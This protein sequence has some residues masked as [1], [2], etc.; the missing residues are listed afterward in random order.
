MI[1]I[2]FQNFK[3]PNNI[4]CVWRLCSVLGGC[5]IIM[6]KP[7]NNVLKNIKRIA[8]GF[9]N[10]NNILFVEDVNKYIEY[11][12][13]NNSNNEIYI[14]ETKEFWDILS[15]NE[16]YINYENIL[17]ISFETSE[18][19]IY[20]VFGHELNGIN[21]EPLKNISFKGVYIPQTSIQSKRDGMNTSLNLGVSIAFIIGV[22]KCKMSV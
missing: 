4:G 1:N 14:A 8:N 13:K 6:E 22:F 16:K 9:E 11:V 19:E 7:Y 12:N 2:I 20:I 18:K 10:D 15:Q 5:K 21:I 3:Y 17:D